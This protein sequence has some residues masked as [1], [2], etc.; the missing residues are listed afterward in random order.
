[1]ACDEVFFAAQ[2]LAGD[3]PLG[4]QEA[5]GRDAQSGMV[6]KPAPAAA[7]IVPQTEV[8]LELLVVAL[9]AP[10]LMGGVLRG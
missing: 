3:E 9:D 5:I 2:R 10:A 4:H 6:V 8:L 7:L 1:M